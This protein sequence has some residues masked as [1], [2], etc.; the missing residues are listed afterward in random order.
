MIR[1]SFFINVN[2]SGTS[3]G[4]VEALARSIKNQVVQTLADGNRLHL[5]ARQRVE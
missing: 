2:G 1:I 3:A 4:C 5:F